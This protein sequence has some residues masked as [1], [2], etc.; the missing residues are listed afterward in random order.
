MLNTTEQVYEELN[1][2][3]IDVS[4]KYSY[5]H[6]TKTDNRS[7]KMS[8]GRIWFNTI[9]PDE[10]RL[11]NDKVNKNDLDKIIKEI[12][13]KYEPKVAAKHVR[14][15]Q[16]HAAKMATYD[17]RTFQK[18]MFE[19]SFEWKE[20]KKEFVNNAKDFTPQEFNAKRKEL[21]D[22]LKKEMESKGVKF[23]EALDSKS[24]GKVS[25]EGWA[26]MQIA[27]G[28]TP[29]VEGNVSFI[30][31]GI[32][33]GYSIKNYYEAA[34]EARAG[35]Y[36]KH[37]AVQ[38]PGYLS[39][40]VIMAN[41]GIKLDPDDCKSK[42]YLEIFI[43]PNRA[44]NFAGRY[45]KL[46]NKLVLIEDSNTISGQ[47]IKIRSPLY[48]KSTKG[49]CKIC[50]GKLAERVNT[51]NIGILAG[52]AVNNSAVN[53]MMKLRHQAEKVSIIEVDFPVII[54]K[55]PINIE[56]LNLI[57]DIRKNDIYARDNLTIE[58]DKNEYDDVSLV[59]YDDKYT[60]PGL[61][62]IRYGNE[63]P[64]YYH[65][66]LN[67]EVNLMKPNNFDV[68]GRI[69]RFNYEKGEK[70][71]H[72]KSYMKGINPAVI[73]KILDSITK[74]VKDPRI[75]VDML[76][77]ELSNIDSVH[78]ELAIGNMFRDNEDHKM[79][80]RLNDYRNPIIIGSKKL[81]FIDSWLSGLAFENIN[82]A[83]ELGL[84][85][86]EDAQFN[87]IEKLIIRDSYKVD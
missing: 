20:K 51:D 35:Y 44:S 12:S 49:I 67:F 74:Y 70:I 27:K 61:L 60:V 23:M 55:S 3:G 78:L 59:E 8:L 73:T 52:G 9:L 32:A 66:P 7:K 16:K 1:K 50:Y 2:E 10:F 85:N 81:P 72:K 6:P 63:E 13:D 45:M 41:A 87:D 65:L 14:N 21:T 43:A 47:T 77:E 75:L 33:D 80:A 71:I 84:V 79:P 48:C 54:Q 83:I 17:P 34:K 37:I 64:E 26:I 69:L 19:P 36:Y 38:D 58:I 57:L 29:D 82:K 4:T 53:A 28:S 68:S 76:S 31:E 46:D 62:S 25:P 42:K 11:I 22:A 24:S 39:R 30:P 40:K 56:Q 15:I 86:E 5:S 18:E